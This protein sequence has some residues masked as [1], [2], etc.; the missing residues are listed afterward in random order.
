MHTRLTVLPPIDA[1]FLRG[2]D[3][4]VGEWLQTNDWRRGWGYNSNFKDKHIAEAYQK[5]FTSEHPVYN[6]SDIYAMPGGWHFPFP[7]SELA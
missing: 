6:E 4:S 1:V 7:D 3:D 2:S 5:T